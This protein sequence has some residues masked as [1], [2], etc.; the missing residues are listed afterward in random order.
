MVALLIYTGMRRSEV[1]G[2]RWEDGDLEGRLIHVR[3]AATFTSNRPIVGTTKTKAGCRAIPITD[4]LL[5]Y[6]QPARASGY[7]IGGDET[8][9]TQSTYDRTMERIG[10]TIN[11]YGA[12]AHVFRHS[13]L[14][15]LGTLNTNIKTIQAI[16]GHSDI[17]TTMNRY[18]HRDV[19]QIHLAGQEFGKKVSE[20]MTK[21]NTPKTL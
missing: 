9:I 17:Q 2:L 10:K 21:T 20:M 3:R 16:A 1:L 4:H 13:Y 12:T 6:L 14:T 5:P 8:P 15:F 7:V 18:V 19:S 11:L